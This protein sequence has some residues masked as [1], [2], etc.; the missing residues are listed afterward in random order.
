MDISTEQTLETLRIASGVGWTYE[1]GRFVS[2]EL[3]IPMHKIP[4]MFGRS[5]HNFIDLHVGK[6]H[7][8]L[9]APAQDL[10]DDQLELRRPDYAMDLIVKGSESHRDAYNNITFT[11]ATY[12]VPVMDLPS[13]LA[14]YP[15]MD[16]M[17]DD[18]I[19]TC[20]SLKISLSSDLAN[21]AAYQDIL[22]HL[23]NKNLIRSV[24]ET[25]DTC[26]VMG[27][28]T[29]MKWRRHTQSYA[30]NLDEYRATL[31][32]GFY[33]ELFMAHNREKRDAVIA[34]LQ[35]F[36]RECRSDSNLP[37]KLADSN[38][39]FSSNLIEQIRWVTDLDERALGSIAELAIPQRIAESQEFQQ[40]LRTKLTPLSPTTI[41][42]QQID[43][44]QRDTELDMSWFGR[45]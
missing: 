25:K 6:T 21:H 12:S 1:N 19:Q 8:P 24:A 31:P 45:K 34:E 42:F 40:I 27:Q 9:L 23:R 16:T 32:W 35:D 2:E 13:K 20:K 17:E 43:K 28:I 29:G 3:A 44:L 15:Y 18:A 4:H 22:I 33:G 30:G 41:F 7:F 36:A 14:K 37:A 39:S 5:F 11:P 10:P 26:S 38:R